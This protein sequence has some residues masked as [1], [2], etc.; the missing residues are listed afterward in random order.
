M[1]STRD[2]VRAGPLVRARRRAEWPASE[3]SLPV[4][5]RRIR[6]RGVWVFSRGCLNKSIFTWTYSRTPSL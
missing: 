6:P 2:M 1:R 3:W 4:D 5:N